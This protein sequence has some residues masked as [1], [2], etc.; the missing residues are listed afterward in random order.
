MPGMMGR[1]VVYGEERVK[2]DVLVGGKIKVVPSRWPNI[3][4][5]DYQQSQRDISKH[6]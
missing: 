6:S 5:L 1:A 4:R 2:G 3:I